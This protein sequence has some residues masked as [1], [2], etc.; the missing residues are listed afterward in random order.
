M[1]FPTT[2]VLDNFNR[3][4]EGPPPSASW[5]AYDASWGF[6]DGLEVVSN[7]CKGNSYDLCADYWNGATYGP[8]CEVYTTIATLPDDISDVNLRLRIVGPGGDLSL[9]SH[10]YTTIE[11]DDVGGDYVRIFRNSSG[12]V[13]PLTGEVTITLVAGD[14]FGFE[15]IGNDLSVYQKPSAGSWT[16]VA[17]VTDGSPLSQVAGYIGVDVTDNV[18]AL[19]DFGGG[20][21]AA[22]GPTAAFSGTPL[23]GPAPLTV[24]FTDASTGTPTSWAWNFGDTETSTD[25]NPTHE[26]TDPGTYTVALTV[27]NDDGSDTETKTDYITVLGPPVAN[28]SGTPLSGTVPLSVDF[29]DSS[30]NSPDT[31]FWDFGDGDS[32]AV[33]NPTHIYNY[34]GVYT[35]TLT[36]SSSAGSDSETKAAYITVTAAEEF[37]AAE[38]ENCDIDTGGAAVGLRVSDVAIARDNILGSV[39]IDASAELR[40]KDN[41]Y[42]TLVNNGTLTSLAGD[43]AVWDTTNFAADHARDID[44]ATYD[45]HNNPADPP[46]SQALTDSHIFVGNVSDIATDVAMS[47]DAT[48]DN[49]GALTIANDAVTYAKIQNITTTQRALG[50]NTAGAGDTEEITASQLLDWLGNTRGAVLYR[51][52]SDWAIL[53]PGDAGYSLTSNGAGADPTY[54]LVS[55]EVLMADGVTPPDP[56]TTEDETDWLYEG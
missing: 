15:R 9:S 56:L 49:T 11:R 10:Y 39:T 38:V 54:Q 50:R 16:Q 36:A 5:S 24:D 53:A 4:N 55:A 29:T 21:I 2:P 13:T 6:G 44:A 1:A 33:Q 52:A 37:G 45:Y 48:I 22:A 27:T 12:S 42:S 7:Q 8:D 34:I 30:T 46:L 35:V 51:G 40:A 19:D 18:S 20:T 47:G 3:A 25:Q 31:W 17:T 26:Y 23:S 43:R 14:S 41:A 32:S 28:F